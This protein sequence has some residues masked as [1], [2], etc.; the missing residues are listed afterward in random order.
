MIVSYSIS[1]GMREL[2]LCI[3]TGA[4]IRLGRISVGWHIGNLLHTS[5]SGVK[6]ISWQV[7]KTA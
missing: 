3:F 4:F 6:K 5:Q 1:Y 7:L 2:R